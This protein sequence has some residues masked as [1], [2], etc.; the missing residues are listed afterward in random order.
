VTP[1]TDG[2]KDH[3]FSAGGKPSGLLASMF[4]KAQSLGLV[5]NNVTSYIIA[6]LPKAE[7]CVK[8]CTCVVLLNAGSEIVVYDRA[9][10]NAGSPPKH[11]YT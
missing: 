7:G 2:A 5:F 4:L 8:I 10:K 1:S 9:R 3:G 6:G 11:N